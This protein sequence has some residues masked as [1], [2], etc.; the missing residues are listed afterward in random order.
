MSYRIFIRF[1]QGVAAVSTSGC[2]QQERCAVMAETDKGKSTKPRRDHE[3]GS[4][5]HVT[6]RTKFVGGLAR[7]RTDRSYPKARWRNKTK[8]K[9]IFPPQKSSHPPDIPTKPFKSPSPR[10]KKGTKQKNSKTMQPYQK[11]RVFINS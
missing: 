10:G 8:N 1:V 4:Q 6:F 7:P 3:L 5:V 11:Q 2:S 9:H